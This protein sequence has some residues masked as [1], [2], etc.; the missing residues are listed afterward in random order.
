MRRVEF[1]GSLNFMFTS[2]ELERQVNGFCRSAAA[3][4]RSG[5]YFASKEH[6]SLTEVVIGA[7]LWG[8]APHS[9]E[10]GSSRDY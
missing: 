1:R 4:R 2:R 6:F 9:H 5:Q 10:I 7:V 3:Q 8:G